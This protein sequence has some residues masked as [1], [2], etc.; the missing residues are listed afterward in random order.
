MAI[1]S[2][3]W[4]HLK[5]LN[6][7]LL[8]HMLQRKCAEKNFLSAYLKWESFS[9]TYQSIEHIETFLFHEKTTPET[10]HK[11]QQEMGQ[12]EMGENISLFTSLRKQQESLSNPYW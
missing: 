6:K 5:A 9:P 2:Q 4:T 11:S 8:F 10:F 7:I 12:Q 3:A 1:N